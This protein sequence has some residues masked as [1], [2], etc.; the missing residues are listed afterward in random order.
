MT[1]FDKILGCL[2]GGAAG[3]AMGAATEMRTRQQIE[4]LFGGYVT[5]FLAPPQDTFARGNKAGQVTDDFS[6]ALTTVE[7]IVE[8]NGLINRDVG[9]ESLIAWSSDDNYFSRFAGP[10]TRAAINALKG[11]TVEEYDFKV[12]NDNAKAS[13]GSAMKIS[14][15]ALFSNGDVDKAIEDAFTIVTISHDN[16]ISISAAAAVA[17]ATAKAMDVNATLF[18]V[19]KAGLYGAQKG[20]EI[21]R[22]R[23][24][25]YAGPSVYK[26]MKLAI[27]I[28]LRTETLS[29]AIDEI[30][31]YIGSGLAAAEAVP[32]VFGL[33]VA[34]KGDAVEAIQAGVNIGYDTDTVATMIGG[35]LGTLHGIQAF[36][37]N[38]LPLLDEANGYDLAKTAKDIEGLL[39]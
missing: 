16:N 36:P 18:D 4:E 30:A 13:N 29:E 26:R 27:D 2:V 22:E 19:V 9:V 8:N 23:A 37:E 7:K 6:L 17:A 5:E 25:T 28:A 31:D 15:I 33:I 10:T 34:A 14:P 21:G 11:N 35:I 20:D 3:D 38:Y 32:A 1:K 39:K 24:Q 12:V